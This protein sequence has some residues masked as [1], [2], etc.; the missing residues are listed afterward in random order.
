MIVSVSNLPSLILMRFLPATPHG[1]FRDDD[2]W[3][4]CGSPIR[5]EDGRFHLFASRWPKGRPFHPGWLYRSQIVRAASNRPEG[6]FQC[7]E[8]VLGPR[9]PSFFDGRT[10]HNPCIRKHGDTYLL[11]YMGCT[12]PENP[13]TAEQVEAGG[14]A[15]KKVWSHKRIGLATSKSVFGPWNRPDKPLIEPRPGHWDSIATTNPAPWIHEDGSVLMVYKSRTDAKGPRLLGLARA[16]HWSG[17]Y[18]AISEKPLFQG[19][20]LEDA[21]LWMEGGTYRMI[22][23]DMDGSVGGEPGCIVSAHSEDGEDWTLDNPPFLH[24]KTLRLDNGSIQQLGNFERPQVLI[25]YEK[26]RPTH[27]FAAVSDGKTGIG[28]A[29]HT[30]NLCLAIDDDD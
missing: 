12:Y 14:E 29:G 17:P 16:P 18:E 3:I 8:T 26:D 2:F 13:D 20:D 21:C 6:P 25:D 11:Y 19:H 10:A 22:L 5:G 4:W 7:E 24:G 27:L 9:D 23:K 30:W 1:G 28:D 15:Y